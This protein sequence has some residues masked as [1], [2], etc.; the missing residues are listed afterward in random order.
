VQ[1]GIRWASGTTTTRGRSWES[2]KGIAR[3]NP[4]VVLYAQWLYYLD[5]EPEARM[6]S[7]SSVEIG[8][9]RAQC[10]WFRGRRSH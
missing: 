7:R 1:P 5:N 4:L 10:H 9:K 8:G 6:H 3:E 2:Q